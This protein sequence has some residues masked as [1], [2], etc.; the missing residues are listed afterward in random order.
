MKQSG[1]SSS[2]LTALLPPFSV[3][4]ILNP[5]RIN[6]VPVINIRYNYWDFVPTQTVLLLKG[7]VC[8]V[9]ASP[10]NHTPPILL[11]TE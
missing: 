3:L 8:G 11:Q 7:R 5:Q 4:F 9:A 1:L 10:L 6:A 2:E